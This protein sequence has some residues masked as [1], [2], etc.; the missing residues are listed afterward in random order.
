[1]KNRALLQLAGVALL[2]LA[3]GFWLRGATFGGSLWNVD[4][5]I[6]AAAARIILDGGVMYRDAIDQRTPLSY[7][8]VAG[9]FAVF[10]EN[11]LWAVR[12]CIA[13]LIAA[14][15]CW[16]HLAASPLRRRGAGLLAALLYVVLSS[17][18]LFSGDAYAANTEWF[19]AFFSSAAA[20][21]FLTG[22]SI[23]SSRR[24][25]S[26]GALLAGAFLSKQPALL[27]AAAPFGVLIYLG[28]QQRQPARVVVGQLLTLIAGWLIPV[29][30]TAAYFW[31]KGALSEAIFYTWTYNLTYYGPEITTAERLAALPGPFVLL[32]ATQGVLVALWALGALGGLH[33]L[34]Q[35]QPTGE[36][37]A[38]N[39]ALLYLVLWSLLAWAGAASSGRSFD[40]YTIQF[41]PAFCLGSGLAIAALAH[42]T[43]SSRRWSIRFATA[44]LLV[45]LAWQLVA[46]ATS[47]RGRTLPGDSS[48]P[49]AAYIRE[50]STPADKIFV[51]GFHADIY[52]HADRKPASR[53]VF[54]SFV[55]G[56]VP[57][58]NVAPGVD[59]TY[60]I[61][62]GTMDL[63]LKDLTAQRPLF[64]VDCSAGPNRHWQKY[65]PENFPPLFDFIRK[66]YR[67]VEASRFLHQ[68]Y[69]VYR[70]LQP[71]EAPDENTAMPPLPAAVA[72]QLTLG[73]LTHPLTPLMASAPH[74]ADRLMSDGRVKYFAHAPAVLSYRVPAG[75]AALRGG[76][77]IEAAAYADDNKGPTDGA[78]F[79]ILWR[80]P[81]GKEQVLLR[82]LLRPREEA[83]DRPIQSFRVA[84]PATVAG[85]ELE[86]AINP[87][88]AGNAASD[89]TYWIDLALE[90]SP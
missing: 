69:R 43:K 68:G 65:P 76:F 26:T 13:L 45:A 15:A 88:P 34:A 32:A 1:M 33:R 85:A 11:N 51:W 48:L 59:T 24:L 82:R 38:S 72:A 89:W 55:T 41:L 14:T 61:V 39:P 57:W 64:I 52:L 71:G 37:T 83:G 44:G 58:T 73:T 25:L 46:A 21:L 67:V 74:G 78:E 10:G 30:L 36:E 29:T 12:C 42:W 60:A 47:S 2:V 84:L 54:A 19:V 27:E 79:V 22:G 80:P 7:Y 4:E 90:N 35:R 66:N 5:S 18:A 28:W 53:Y 3:G 40:H 20:A 62:P 75:A 77:G 49:V 87:G 31:A 63:L 9:I 81:G 8:A 16:L 6:H 17:A 50:H 23:P 70:R 56:M 86:L